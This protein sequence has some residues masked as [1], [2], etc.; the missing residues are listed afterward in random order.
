MAGLQIAM[1]LPH[2]LDAQPAQLA[3]LSGIITHL[4]RPESFSRKINL[5]VHNL[6]CKILCFPFSFLKLGLFHSRNFRNSLLISI[7]LF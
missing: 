6:L 1:A 4:I 3:H 7:F 5:E 2:N